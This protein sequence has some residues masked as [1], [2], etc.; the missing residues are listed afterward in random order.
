MVISLCSEAW[1]TGSAQCKT[2]DL[3]VF[4]F[5]SLLG[6]WMK[7]NG[8][9][10]KWKEEGW[11]QRGA[12]R[13][14]EK[15]AM[16]IAGVSRWKDGE[17]VAFTAQLP[18]GD[19]I[20]C[21][22]GDGCHRTAGPLWQG[23]Y[24]RSS[25]AAFCAWVCVWYCLCTC[26]PSMEKEEKMGGCTWLCGTQRSPSLFKMLASKTTVSYQHKTQIRCRLHTYVHTCSW[27]FSS[28]LSM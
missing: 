15:A 20:S 7:R 27:R 11:G 18:S 25:P 22:H 13:T 12:R 14:K 17:M 19:A 2:Q 9:M 6:F 1:V 28:S 8:A 23:G 21:L 3:S 26:A 24:R 16:A 4:F 5:P 10:G